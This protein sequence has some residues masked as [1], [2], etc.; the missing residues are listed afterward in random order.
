[1]ML[2][3]KEDVIEHYEPL[4]YTVGNGC[5]AGSTTMASTFPGRPD[6]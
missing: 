1:M 4:K 3:M 5:F 6:Y 2:M